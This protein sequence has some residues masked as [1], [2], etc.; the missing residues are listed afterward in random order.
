MKA[1]TKVRSDLSANAQK[2]L[3]LIVRR[4]KSKTFAIGKPETYLGYKECCEYLGITPSDGGVTWG[5]LLQ[6]N[7]LNELNEWTKHYNF[8]RV[9]GLIVNQS[10]DRQYLPGGDFFKSNG[11]NETD[12]DWWEDQVKSAAAFDWKGA[13]KVIS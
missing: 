4:M 12:F 7:G 2:L 1:V 13:Q 6:Q 11:R 8:P 3:E 9:S 5:Q 10:R